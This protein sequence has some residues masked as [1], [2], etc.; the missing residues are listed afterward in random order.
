MHH[1]VAFSKINSAWL[2][3]LPSRHVVH[4]EDEAGR[5]VPVLP[6]EPRQEDKLLVFRH[7]EPQDSQ[8]ALEKQIVEKFQKNELAR[9][10]RVALKQKG[11]MHAELGAHPKNAT[12][13]TQLPTYL[14]AH[15]FNY[16]APIQLL[17][18]SKLLNKATTC[19]PRIFRYLHISTKKCAIPSFELFYVCN[20]CRLEHLLRFLA[21][22][23]PRVEG[24]EGT[25]ICSVGHDLPRLPRPCVHRSDRVPLVQVYDLVFCRLKMLGFRSFCTFILFISSWALG[26]AVL[27]CS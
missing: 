27:Q 14:L 18:H 3:S 5:P 4:K 22:K 23:N 17:A 25:Y 2:R 13:I 19:A 12:A 9:I 16:C 21:A 11:A 15:S 26:F 6:G 1:L 8:L 20:S 24:R 10:K 7:L